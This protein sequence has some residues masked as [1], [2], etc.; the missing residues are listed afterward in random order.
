MNR[1]LRVALALTVCSFAGT[2]LVHAQAPRTWVSGVGDDANPCSRTAPCLTFAGA[3][4]NT[5]PGGEISVLDPGD[6]GPLTI[7]ASL[8]ISGDGTLGGILIDGGSAILIS[9]A[10]VVVTIRNLAIIGVGPCPDNGISV[11]GSATVTMDRVA[12]SGF[13]TGVETTSGTATV[14]NSTLTQNNDFAIH[15]LGGEIVVE[16]TTLAA[17]GIAV[18]S[19]AGA[20]VRLS[21]NAVYNNLTGF[22]CGGGILASAGNN[23]KAN[24]V[25]GSVPACAPNANVTVQ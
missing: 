2:A 22:G 15:A 16:N 24:N 7:T 9:G 4:L 23:R 18:Q 10:G 11:G 17:N 14:L 25:G 19:D 3:L 13:R 1:A 5:A 21:N 20:T 8:T 6:Y 12:I